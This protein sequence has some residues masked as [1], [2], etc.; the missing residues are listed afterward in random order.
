MAMP[1]PRILHRNWFGVTGPL[2]QEY[3]ENE[4]EFLRLHPGWTSHLHCDRSS[5][6]FPRLFH[7]TRNHAQQS[8]IV[9][10]E[11]I[12]R[13]GGVY[14]DCDVVPLK[15]FEPLLDGVE[16]FCGS[17]DGLNVC[18]AVFGATPE[19]PFI[20]R[21]L[22]LVPRFFTKGQFR[23]G[24][25]PDLFTEAVKGL[26]QVTVFPSETFYPYNWTEKNRAGEDFPRSF[27]VHRWAASW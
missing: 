26:P 19:H 15:C 25:G 13:H 3:Q 7:R 21:C 12:F 6:Y 8:D 11:Y 16:A 17:H 5:H 22:N 14:M 18:N 2:P 27:A 24:T 4:K 9:R 23:A 20:L 10:L 1:I